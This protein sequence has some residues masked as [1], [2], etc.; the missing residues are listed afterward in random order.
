MIFEAVKPT[1]MPVSEPGPRRSDTSEAG[2]G[3]EEE[4]SGKGAGGQVAAKIP[5]VRREEDKETRAK[6]KQAQRKK[7]KLR[8]AK[9]R[10]LKDAW[11]LERILEM[12]P[13]GLDLKALKRLGMSVVV[14]RRLGIDVE[15]LKP[16][17]ED[18]RR[19]RRRKKPG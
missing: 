18:G 12:D 15:A 13:E 4:A 11:R 14:L 3:K 5:H 2:P 16:V 6:K 19:G 17:R 7:A 10:R 9:R 8:K 1:L